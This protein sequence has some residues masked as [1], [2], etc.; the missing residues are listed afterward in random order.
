MKAGTKAPRQ[1]WHDLHCKIDGPA[2]YDVL[3]NFEQ[4][5]RKATKWTELG[6]RFKQKSHWSDDSLIKI[7]RIS[8][9]L[10]PHLS[11]T[12]DGIT[13]VPSDDPTVYVSRE[14]D[15]DHWHVQV[16]HHTSLILLFRLQ[17]LLLSSSS[18]SY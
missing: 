10:S 13:V 12:K 9:I 3:I 18:S 1:P 11:E 14:E 8:W 15:P 17:P 5:W 2:A 4:R 7:E 6:L 16:V